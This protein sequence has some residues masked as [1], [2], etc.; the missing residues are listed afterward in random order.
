M[1]ERR[2]V[3]VIPLLLIGITMTEIRKKKK[4]GRKKK[5]GRKRRQVGEVS[6]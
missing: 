4:K 3:T 5:G 1:D 2:I 6:R